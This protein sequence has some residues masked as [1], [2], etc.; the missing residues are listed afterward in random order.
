MR[1]SV[2][3]RTVA[4]CQHREE[5]MAKK[6]NDSDSTL[7]DLKKRAEQGSALNAQTRALFPE[8]KLVA[9]EDRRL[10]RGKMGLVEGAALRG[11][12]DAIDLEPA[13]FNTLADEDEGHDP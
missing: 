1:A 10:S 4:R 6:T 9:K 13:I 2:R 11:V 12:V 5:P 7:A 3:L 8:A